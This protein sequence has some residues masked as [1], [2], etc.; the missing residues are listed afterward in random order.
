MGKTILPFIAAFSMLSI[1]ATTLYAQTEEY[2][3]LNPV[4]VPHF[5]AP[6]VLNRSVEVGIVGERDDLAVKNLHRLVGTDEE[7]KLHLLELA[8]A[9][10]IVA[11]R[12][13]V[14]EALAL[15]LSPN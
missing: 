2:E 3:K 7:L 11:R 6:V 8:A 9:E 14:A 10:R 15:S 5:P 12:D 1:F 13:L 4:L